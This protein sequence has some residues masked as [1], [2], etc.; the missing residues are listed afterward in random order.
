[1]RLWPGLCPGDK[2]ETVIIW[3]VVKPKEKGK[4]IIVFKQ[5]AVG[6]LLALD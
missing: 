5:I 2:S 4:D 1:M 3:T 6:F